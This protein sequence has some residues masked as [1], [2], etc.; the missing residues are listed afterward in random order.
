[1]SVPAT[2]AI[3]PPT[4][5]TTPVDQDART[6]IPTKLLDQDDFLQLVVAQMSNQ[7]PLKPQSDTEFISQMTTFTTLEQTKSMTADIAQMKIQ[8]EVLKGMS[9]MNREVVVHDGE[10]GNKTGVVTGLD[11]DG[12]NVKVVV[13]DKSF[14]LGDVLAVHLTVPQN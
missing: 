5:L 14:A 4:T 11:M 8:Q 6:R 3:S 13:G 1:M 7:D 10:A 12:Q 9:L 2:T